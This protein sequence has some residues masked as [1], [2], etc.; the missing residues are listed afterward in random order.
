MQLLDLVPQADLLLKLILKLL[1]AQ[2]SPSPGEEFRLLD[3]LAQEIVTA[4]F[5]PLYSIG[6]V[7]SRAVRKITG[8]SRVRSLDFMRRQIS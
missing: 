8:I 1:H 7:V 5:Q 2:S 6:H 3:R 4:G